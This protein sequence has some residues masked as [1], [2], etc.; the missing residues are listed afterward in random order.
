MGDSTTKTRSTSSPLISPHRAS[1]CAAET[2]FGKWPSA[3][4]VMGRSNIAEPVVPMAKL[5][6]LNYRMARRTF[7]S[8]RQTHGDHAI[9]PLTT[10]AGLWS[11]AAT[12][13]WRV[14]PAIHYGTGAAYLFLK[15]AGGWN[16][17]SKFDASFTAKSGKVGNAFGQSVSTTENGVLVGAYLGSVGS[18][19]HQRA[20]YV[21]QPSSRR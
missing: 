4:T 20:A 15:P 10:W 6:G 11:S 3:A 7:H 16:P 5:I 1:P 2:S 13:S 17:T 12:V 18:H 8:S 21:F 9:L 14:R 19:F